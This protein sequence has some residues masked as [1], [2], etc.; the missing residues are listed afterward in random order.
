MSTF[1]PKQLP[2]VA[3]LVL[4]LSAALPAQAVVVTTGCVG[5]SSC[6]LAELYA[7]GTIAINDVLFDSWVLNFDDPG[8]VDE[9]TITV[10]GID[11]VPDGGDPSKA[12]VGL[13]FD[14]APPLAF[15]FLEYDFD[16][17]ASMVA[18]TRVLTGASLELTGFS[19][20]VPADAFVEVNSALSGVLLSV[21]NSGPLLDAE[22][23]PDTASLTVD[24]DIQ[25][26]EFDVG[27]LPSLSGFDYRFTVMRTTLPQP[28]PEPSTLLLLG[29]AVLGVAARRRR[30]SSSSL[31]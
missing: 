30:T 28:A 18:T 4:L 24:A 2:G 9:T 3:G 31:R 16:F 21:D 7:G 22:T 15:E 23:F 6:T 13:D 25:M 8:S 19:V 29:I 10:T 27:G 1:H 11:E 14:I 12:T 5:G 17:D 20:A 26:E